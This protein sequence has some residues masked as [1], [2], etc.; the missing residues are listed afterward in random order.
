MLSW[1]FT[2]RKHDLARVQYVH[3]VCVVCVTRGCDRGCDPGSNEFTPA[4]FGL[5]VLV[6]VCVCRVC[7]PGID[8]DIEL[9]SGNATVQLILQGIPRASVLILP[10]GPVP[11]HRYAYVPTVPTR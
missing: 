6:V 11:Y 5:S 1:W 8:I 10:G 2:P 7:D 9:H 4:P 3:T